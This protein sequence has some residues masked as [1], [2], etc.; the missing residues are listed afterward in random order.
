MWGADTFNRVLEFVGFACK[1]FPIDNPSLMAVYS[2]PGI[3][4]AFFS[5]IYARGWRASTIST[6]STA[7]DKV[8]VWCAAKARPLLCP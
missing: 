3:L 4:A 2:N 7:I 8:L 1:Y 5:F 6:Q